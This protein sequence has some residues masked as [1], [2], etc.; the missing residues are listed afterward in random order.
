MTPEELER[1]KK[2]YGYA[3]LAEMLYARAGTVIPAAQ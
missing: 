3:A 2:L 1:L